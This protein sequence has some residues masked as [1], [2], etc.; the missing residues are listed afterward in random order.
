M[1]GC[2]VNVVSVCDNQIH[3]PFVAYRKSCCLTSFALQLPPRFL[4]APKIAGIQERRT[5]SVYTSLTLHVDVY[6]VFLMD[7]ERLAGSRIESHSGL[8]ACT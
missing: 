5:V 1:A 8:R 4:A 2:D 3:L 6:S 7:L